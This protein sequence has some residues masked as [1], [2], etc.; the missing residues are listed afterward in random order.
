VRLRSCL[1]PEHRP[2]QREFQVK[3]RGRCRVP[4]VVRASQCPFFELDLHP[5]HDQ[6]LAHR[7][8]PRYDPDR[9]LRP[10]RRNQMSYCLAQLDSLLF[11]PSSR[12]PP[13]CFSPHKPPAMTS[14]LR[15]R[16]T[17]ASF[18]YSLAWPQTPLRG[19]CLA[20]ASPTADDGNAGHA[21]TGFSPAHAQTGESEKTPALPP[22]NPR[23]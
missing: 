3:V 7:G 22:R 17:A 15:G 16:I 9:P 8:W 6:T 23:K 18:V 14:P 1:A 13:S 10:T 20:I 4:V 11:P 19:R 5:P 2:P 12:R 21:C